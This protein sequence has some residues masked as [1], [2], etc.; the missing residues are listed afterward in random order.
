MDQGHSQDSEREKMSTG[1]PCPMSTAN[2]F[3]YITWQWV[4]PLITAG[5]KKPLEG[6]D[7]YD[8]VHEET[9][10]E[11]ERRWNKAMAEERANTNKAHGEP[12]SVW[13]LLY[14]SMGRKFMLGS[15]Y[16]VAWLVAVVLQVYILR[17]LVLIAQST[18]HLRWWWAT[19]L[20]VG[21]LATC[22]TQ[23]ITQHHCFTI[24][25]RTGMKA[26]ATVAMAVFNKLQEMRLASLVNTNTGIMLN[27]VTNDTQKILDAATFFHFVWFA[28]V[29][30][31]VVGGLVLYEAGVAAIPGVV[32]IFL[33]QPLQVKVAQR[34]GRL[35]RTAINFTDS[36]VSSVNEVLTGVRVVK[37][38]GWTAAFLKR[39]GDLRNSEMHWI[40]RANFLRASTSTLRD[41]VTPLASLATFGTYVAVHGGAA[42][43]PS[44][45]FTILALFSILVRLFSIAPLGVQYLSEALVA[46]QRLQQLLDLPNGH[47]LGSS[48]ETDEVL[49]TKAVSVS[50]GVFSWSLKGWYS[51]E[52]EKKKDVK[53]RKAKQDTGLKILTHVPGSTDSDKDFEEAATLKEITF[54][55]Q[56]GELV[57]IVGAVGSGKSSLLMALLGEMECVTGV[58]LTD[59]PVAY[60]P[61]QP[62]ILNDTIRSNILFGNEFDEVRYNETVTA[63]ALDHDI[64]QLPAGHDTEIGE[65][66]V[67]LSGGQKA[68][69]S[70]ARACYSTS[71]LLLLDD[72][73]AA[74]DV[75]TAKHLM[76][77]VLAGILKERTV[78]LVT[79][80]KTS[81]SFCNR[82][83]LM[84]HGRLQE[85][86]KDS[87]LD[88]ELDAVILDDAE[89]T[90]SNV[91]DHQSRLSVNSER[92]DSSEDLEEQD[93]REIDMLDGAASVMV[94]EST[95][96]HR[97]NM[98]LVSENVEIV[99]SSSKKLNQKK[100]ISSRSADGKKLAGSGRL[101][102]VKS[103]RSVNKGGQLTV[104]EDRVEGEVT[105]ATYAQYAKDGGGVAFFAF[106]TFLFLFAQAVRVM[107]D[108]WLSIW[109]DRGYHLS[110]KIYVISYAC[111][112]AGAIILSLSR[113]LLFTEAAMLSAKQMHGRMAERVLRSPQLFFDQNPVGRIVNRF[114]KDQ[115]LVDEILPSTAQTC[116]ENFTG[117]LGSIAIMAILIPWF[118]LCLPPF[119]LIFLYV[120]RRYVTVSRELKRLDGLS[121]SP[122]YAHFSQTLQ[123]IASVRAFGAEKKMH[124]QF[125]AMIDANHRA[126][127][128]FV[129]SSRWLGIRLDFAAAICVSVASLLVVLLRNKISPGLAGVVLVQ[130]LQLTGFFQ[131]GVRLA[132]ETENYFTSVERIQA[133]SILPTEA[134]PDTA[135]GI[136]T[137]DWPQNGEIEFVHYTMA[138]RV[139]LPP[140]LNDLCFKVK[141][142]EKVGILG[143][144]GAGK[145]SL[146]AAMFRLVENKAC[147]GSILID[148]IDIAQVGLDDLRR[149][150]SI[151]PQDPV[152]FKGTVRLN[153]DPFEQHTDVEINEAIARVHLSKKIKT[154]DKGIDSI[155]AENGENFSVGQRQLLCL[156]RSLL[157][158]SRV[159]VMDEATAAVD[160]ETDQL[161]QTTMR[162]VFHNCTVLT[163]AHRIDTIIDCHRVLVL[164]KGGRLAEFDT[165]ANLLRRA[166]GV[167]TGGSESR[168]VGN[169]GFAD[170]VA[171]SGEV[172]AR[173]LRE[174]AEAAELRRQEER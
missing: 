125:L 89:V 56:R 112:A 155:V 143:R 140:V 152:L 141:A 28:L 51:G 137:E 69:I 170:I 14:K 45:A 136:I 174:A 110:T 148:G 133:Y 24:G 35:R 43:T 167:S 156:A 120:Q 44:L 12:V 98:D 135:P 34:V 7:L 80:N 21:M 48:S 75:P 116:L 46:I 62:W 161:I 22:M 16:K 117:C 97:A 151:I 65:R 49:A 6:E 90:H 130:S 158:R 19:I 121:R 157:R 163:I 31:A 10:R 99:R 147:S 118:L 15:L 81:L 114:S 145:S 123:G 146:A 96:D 3:S 103:E 78:I 113:A 115:S 122:M 154:L 47:G 86:A 74:V 29:E 66:G 32:L 169:H 173:Q 70:L 55:V 53:K 85:I 25:Q 68:R 18:G 111:F 107:V 36:R 4:Q 9:S 59:R 82:I 30:V 109:V 87:L 20:V 92:D 131:Y 132:A 104:K 61:Q 159:I 50:K 33:T 39:I 71:P 8:L 5:N 160:G 67:N 153:L 27:L 42:L 106:V 94:A 144:T 126:F 63:C 2:I 142:Q 79:H 40:K 57:A 11:C 77:H 108:Y 84:E 168:G 83:Y 166:E 139:D 127:V 88:G 1:K 72:P 172:I 93:G 76:D 165:P 38:N 171:Q 64:A 138:Y 129:H 102:D 91:N 13:K 17:A 100:L 60:A 124:D 134:D 23:S 150:L 26:R 37:Y 73:L 58:S 149:R 41:G 128:L 162:S 164:A 101:S 54:E 119:V 52:N 95:Q 105:W